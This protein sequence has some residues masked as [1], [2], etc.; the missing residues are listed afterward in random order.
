MNKY[1]ICGALA[2]GGLAAGTASAATLD[3][4]KARGK[5]NCG[6]TTGVAGFAAP[7]ANGVWEG[8]D[9][10]VCRAVAAAILATRQLLILHR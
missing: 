1:L 3:D 4:V 9:V 10:D 7:D 8:L 5:L 6:V 2:L